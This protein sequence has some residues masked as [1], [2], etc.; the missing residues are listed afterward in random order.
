VPVFTVTRRHS[1]G[2][3]WL[4]LALLIVLAA[5]LVASCAKQERPPAGAAP[6]WNKKNK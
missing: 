6:V 2:A 5:P 3:R 4:A 1:T